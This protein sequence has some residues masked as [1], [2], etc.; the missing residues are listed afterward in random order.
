MA[1]TVGD[2]G[3]GNLVL[4]IKAIETDARGSLKQVEVNRT[5]KLSIKSP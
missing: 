1:P 4:Q 3:C 5:A 2:F